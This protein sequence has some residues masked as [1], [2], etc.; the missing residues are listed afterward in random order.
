M[1]KNLVAMLPSWAKDRLRIIRARHL[2]SEINNLTVSELGVDGDGV[3]WIRLNDGIIFYGFQPNDEMRKLYSLIN[4]RIPAIS[5]ICFK[6]VFDI[7]FC[8][9]APRNL[10]GGLQCQPSKYHPLRD[11]LNDFNVGRAKKLE[12]AR[13]FKP[14]E[15][16][17]FLDIGSYTGY[18]AMKIASLVGSSGKVIV[19][20]ADPS[21]LVVLKK[22]ITHNNLK[23]IDVI[24]KA[25]GKS[26]GKTKFYRS[27]GTANSL[28][29]WVL[30]RKGYEDLKSINVDVVSV[31]EALSS[32]NI[33]DVDM[34]NITINGA[35]HDALL[36][37]KMLLAQSQNVRI[38]LAGWYYVNENERVCDLAVPY[39]EGLNFKVMK[40]KLGRVLA[41]KTNELN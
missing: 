31:D 39:L 5:E 34:I 11:P 13:F 15:G 25:V 9:L 20:E 7:V 28:D 41:W 6:V 16:D 29:E 35:E 37:M 8:Y 26:S 23:N 21:V 10:P 24:E 19:F 22:N 33:R 36:G 17:T 27:E 1:I 4:D 40:G 38:T 12:L 2:I 3:P 14:K 18:G 30:K 32:M